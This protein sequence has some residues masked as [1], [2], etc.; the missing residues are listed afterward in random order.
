MRA[1]GTCSRVPTAEGSRIGSPLVAVKAAHPGSTSEASQ[2]MDP[3]YAVRKGKRRADVR[4]VGGKV[5]QIVAATVK[6]F[7]LDEL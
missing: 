1:G 5:T 6:A 2:E 4:F 7:A 3:Y